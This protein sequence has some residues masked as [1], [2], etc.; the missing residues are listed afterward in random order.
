MSVIKEW[1]D[2]APICKGCGQ[3]NK[4]NARV[5][6]LQTGNIYFVCSCGSE[7]DE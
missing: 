2:K 3:Q 1:E 5:Q 7:Q 6:N 4:W